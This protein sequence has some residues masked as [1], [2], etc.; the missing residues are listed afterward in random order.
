MKNNEISTIFQTI[1][2]TQENS[3]L[4]LPG[5]KFSY[6]LVK[7]LNKMKSHLKHLYS[8]FIVNPEYREY[9]IKKNKINEENDLPENMKTKK[10]EEYNDE[11][12]KIMTDVESKRVQ[13]LK[14]LEEEYKEVLSLQKI[15]T[16]K[17]MKLMEEEVEIDFHMIDR[18]NLP[19]LSSRQRTILSFMIVGEANNSLLD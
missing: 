19:E 4:D 17:R 7:N 18:E 12:K 3:V 14:E 15:E 8:T 11:D 1:A 16:E 10:I 5:E 6:A 9:E 13:L 2:N